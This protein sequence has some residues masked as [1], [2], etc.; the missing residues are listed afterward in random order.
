MT[1]ALATA[2]GNA[3][4]NIE[5]ITYSDMRS[6]AQDIYESRLFGVKSAQEAL[7]LM[8]LAQSE[9]LHPM[10]AIQ[11]YSIIQGKPAMKSAAMLARFQRD[12]GTHKFT[13]YTKTRVTGLFT[14][15]RGGELE[16]TWTLD[17]AKR[18]G[19]AGKDNWKNYPEAML[20]AR[21]AA[22]AVRALAPGVLQGMYTVEEVR[23]F[24]P[25]EIEAI[26]APPQLALVGSNEDPAPAQLPARPEFEEV[27]EEEPVAPQP[28]PAQQQAKPAAA[29]SGGGKPRPDQDF[30]APEDRHCPFTILW[31]E[32]RS[33]SSG[34]DYIVWALR[35]DQTKKVA[36]VQCWD[37][38]DAKNV[39]DTDDPASSRSDFRAIVKKGKGGYWAVAEFEMRAGDLEEDGFD[40]GDLGPPLDMEN[41]LEGASRE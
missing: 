34:K 16:V 32:S 31:G 12:G 40:A 36:Y 18:I 30:S 19:L 20:T 33:A 27:Q 22:Q 21:V 1:K 24:T 4:A 6:M 13:V 11:E 15:P 26:P 14:H 39:L 41:P 25:Q 7:G 3:P 29:P 23:D 37:V 8:L 9:G 10:K 35:N 28:E 5:H 17:D 2:G 38:E